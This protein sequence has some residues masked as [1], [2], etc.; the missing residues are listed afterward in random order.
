MTRN[1]AIKII[2]NQQKPYNNPCLICKMAK[3]ESCDKRWENCINPIAW[4]ESYKKK[5][6]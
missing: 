5:F 6:K 2:L 4:A 3:K 1:E